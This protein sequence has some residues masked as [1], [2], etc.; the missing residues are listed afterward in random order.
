MNS[1]FDLSS[2]YVLNYV[3]ICL[4]RLLSYTP[5]VLHTLSHTHTV[6]FSVKH[7]Q[8]YPRIVLRIVIHIVSHTLLST[9]CPL[10]FTLIQFLTRTV[11]KF[12]ISLFFSSPVPLVAWYLSADQLD[13]PLL[14]KSFPRFGLAVRKR[15]HTNR[16]P[17]FGI[18]RV[19]EP[20]HG[21]CRGGEGF[22]DLGGIFNSL[23]IFLAPFFLVQDS[24]FLH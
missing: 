14:A 13:L 6:I 4:T 20:R 15:Q 7:E 10:I 8:S 21:W 3:F 11:T 12:S 2:I 17:H 1:C 23:T 16:R 24:P 9:L 22:L 5:T 19:H 18:R